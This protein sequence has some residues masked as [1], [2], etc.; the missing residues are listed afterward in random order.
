MKIKKVSRH[1]VYPRV[2]DFLCMKWC[3]K[4]CKIH[5]VKR[6]EILEKC[7]D[8]TDK[9][10]Q[11]NF[12][13]RKLFE[14]EFLKEIVLTKKQKELIKYQFRFINFNN[15]KESIMFL[16]SLLK[17]KVKLTP[18]LLE[19]NMKMK[20]PDEKLIEGVKNYYNF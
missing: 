18:E 17:E 1:R 13:M 16:D 3:F 5:K 8:I 4:P 12:I 14:I 11:I 19:S 10:M 7:I 2:G 9:Y 15:H 6:F 20:D